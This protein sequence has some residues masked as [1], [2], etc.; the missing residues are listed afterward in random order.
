MVEDLGCEESEECGEKSS[1]EEKVN[2]EVRRSKRVGDESGRSES[3]REEKSV[4]RR[5]KTE[6]R[7]KTV[8]GKQEK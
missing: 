4:N 3:V 8:G 1:P 7:R 2:R 5:Q 6:D